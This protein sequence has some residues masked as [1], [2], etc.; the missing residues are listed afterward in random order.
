M[1][2]KLI[3][4]CLGLVLVVALAGYGLWLS[5]P[6]VLGGLVKLV[7][8]GVEDQMGRAV[9]AGIARPGAVC[10]D[11][12][13]Q[14]EINKIVA[15]LREVMPG[16]PYNFRVQ[17]VRQKEVNALAAP[18][19]HIVVFSGLVRRM[20]T[21][22]QLAAVLAHE[23]QHVVQRHSVKGMVRALGLQAALMLLVGDVGLLGDLAGNLTA[24]HFMRGDEQSA[25]DVAL[26]TL[27]RAG[28]A[29]EAM[30]QAFRNLERE[31]RGTTPA[32]FKY[33]SSHPPLGERM[34]RV[35]TMAGGWKGPE[36]KLD[37]DLSRV[38]GG[39]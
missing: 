14:G 4:L 28:I 39:L 9:V 25:D 13:T 27:M 10:D 20:E 5:V 23:M 11:A 3:L 18:G 35:G 12:G 6:L 29:P 8:V 17:V 32:V 33:L 2:R 1:I 24:L 36:R 7:P 22:E 15:R 30:R 21:P 34:E 38:C 19:G 16:Q 31:E 26:E 37:V